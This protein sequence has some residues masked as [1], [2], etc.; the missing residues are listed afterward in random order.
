MYFIVD[1]DDLKVT[2]KHLS[3]PQ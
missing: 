1:T 3:L 2:C